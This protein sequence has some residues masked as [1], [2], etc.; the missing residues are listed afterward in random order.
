MTADFASVVLQV[1]LVEKALQIGAGVHAG[2]RVRLK[3]HQIAALG[4]A[5]GFEEV[6]EADLK[7]IGRRGVAGDMTALFAAIAIGP[8]HHEHGVPADRCAQLGFQRFVAGVVR[9]SRQRDA[10]AVGRDPGAGRLHAADQGVVGQLVEQKLSALDPVGGNDGVE[11]FQPLAGFAGV[12]VGL[13]S[14]GG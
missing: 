9:L 1:L 11:G 6:L 8:H 12:A 2:R 14:G 3:E 4:M 7:Q 10:I 13:A 5:V